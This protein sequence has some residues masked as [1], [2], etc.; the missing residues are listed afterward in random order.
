MIFFQVNKI[1]ELYYYVNYMKKTKLK[2]IN[3]NIMII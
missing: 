1:I 2:T 3:N